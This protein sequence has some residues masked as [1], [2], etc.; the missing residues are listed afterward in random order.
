[1][2]PFNRTRKLLSSIR[3]QEKIKNEAIAKGDE[4]TKKRAERAIGELK[5]EIDRI[6]RDYQ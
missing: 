2:E 1:M 6:A 3:A 4:V 5:K